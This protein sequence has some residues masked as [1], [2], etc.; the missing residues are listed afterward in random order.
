MTGSAGRYRYLLTFFRGQIV[1][2]VGLLL[3][4]YLVH[5]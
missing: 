2:V 4:V 5:E 3:S 1:G